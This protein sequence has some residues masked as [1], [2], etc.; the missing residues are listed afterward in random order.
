MPTNQLYRFSIVWYPP[1]DDPVNAH[2]FVK[3]AFE[4]ISA[5]YIFQLERGHDAGKLHFQCY[6]N[7]KVKKRDT[8]LCKI[9]NASGMTKLTT[10]T[11]KACSTAGNLALEK[12]CMKS[13]TRE[14]GPWA[15]HI[16]YLGR[17]LQCMDHPLPFQGHILQ[18]IQEPPDDRTINWVYNEHG[19]AGK[20][21]LTKYIE[22]HNLGIVVEFGTTQQIKAAL[23]VE[24]PQPAYVVDIPRTIGKNDHINDILNVLEHLKNGLVKS[25]M[26]GKAAKMFLEPPHVWV[27]SNQMPCLSRLSQDRWKLWTITSENKLQII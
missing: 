19:C 9:L 7:L 26:Y 22:F 12:Y 4:S 15:D 1:P 18:S 10:N 20:S 25:Y 23:I 8:E 2:T 14:A 24:G 3:D 13:D 16:I 21:K 11:I 27:F 5:K 6:V 17:D